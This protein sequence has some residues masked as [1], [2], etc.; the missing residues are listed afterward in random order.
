MFQVLSTIVVE[1]SY[2]LVLAAGLLLSVLPL[3]LNLAVNQTRTLVVV[4]LAMMI[5]GLAA[6][7]LAARYRDWLESWLQRRAERWPFLNRWVIPPVHSLLNGFS[8]LNRPDFFALS[9]GLLA[10][11]WFLAIFRDWALI[12]QL[13]PDAP[14]W[15]AAL[16]ISAANLGGALPSTAASLGV[17]EGA[18]V[19]ALALVGVAPEAGLAYALIV[20]VTHL[21]SSSLIGAY[22]LSQ[23][24]KSL[25]ALYSELRTV[26]RA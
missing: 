4:L 20:H 16:A 8:V 17:F 5:A 1:R 24:G 25:T 18:A 22:G 23:E 15:W 13:V 3:V 21:I 26:N 11:S 19:A 14:L 10:F 6:L 2:D 7:Y 12:R 9:F